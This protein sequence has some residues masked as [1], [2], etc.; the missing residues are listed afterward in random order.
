MIID[1]HDCEW[2][3]YVPGEYTIPSYNTYKCINCG[4]KFAKHLWGG[5]EENIHN[6]QGSCEER[7][8]LRMIKDIIE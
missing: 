3:G 1:D 2:A 8:K 4:S 6:M 5:T 7:K